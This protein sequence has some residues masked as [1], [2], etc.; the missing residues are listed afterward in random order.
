MVRRKDNEPGQTI[1]TLILLRL[2]GDLCPNRTQDRLWEKYSLNKIQK[3]A[4]DSR[5][6]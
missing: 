4:Y 1:R 2:K 5:Q 6:Q 3:L